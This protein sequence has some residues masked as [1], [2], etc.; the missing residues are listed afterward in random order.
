MCYGTE[1][2]VANA[3]WILIKRARALFPIR[4][5]GVGIGIDAVR[6]FPNYL[7]GRI[8]HWI[9]T[10]TI[11]PLTG[12][13]NV[14]IPSHG[15]LKYPR[16]APTDFNSTTKLVGHLAMWMPLLAEFPAHR[17]CFEVPTLVDLVSLIN[18]LDSSTISSKTTDIGYLQI[19]TGS[20][21]EQSS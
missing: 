7:Y 19:G 8:H 16:R 5:G 15:F 14:W 3:S 9:R 18:H 17:P 21:V 20:C 6:K 13:R 2:P 4:K 1:F 11:S 12:R 10:P